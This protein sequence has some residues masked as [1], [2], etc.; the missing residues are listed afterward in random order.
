VG[1]A[2]N[3]KREILA[4]FRIRDP[5]QA[6]GRELILSNIGQKAIFSRQDNERAKL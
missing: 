5:L 1:K 2:F 4:N 6:V 3:D